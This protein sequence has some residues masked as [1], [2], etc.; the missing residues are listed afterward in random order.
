MK[1]NNYILIIFVFIN[2]SHLVFGGSIKLS[3]K[4]QG[5]FSGN[6]WINVGD[7]KY[8]LESRGINAIAFDPSNPNQVKIKICDTYMPDKDS[9]NQLS[10]NDFKNFVQE[11]VTRQNWVL[12]IV[13]FDDSYK[14]MD[15]DLRQWFKKYDIALAYRGSYALVLQSNGFIYN[16]IASNSL[17][18]EGSSLILDSVTISY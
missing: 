17:P 1:P 3:L 10:S 5:Y 8:F 12:A 9:E 6:S 11:I 18:I 16:K 2:I 4:S 15:G 14:N 7:M 13:S